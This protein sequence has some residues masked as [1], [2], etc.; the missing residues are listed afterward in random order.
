[1]RIAMATL[2]S[3]SVGRAVRFEVMHG[4][5]SVQLQVSMYSPLICQEAIVMLLGLAAEY[6]PARS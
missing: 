5:S 2:Q 3:P 4:H 6:G 1:M